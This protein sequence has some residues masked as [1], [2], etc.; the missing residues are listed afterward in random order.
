M[1][2][3]PKCI[4]AV[5]INKVCSPANTLFCSLVAIICICVDVT[6]KERIKLGGFKYNKQN[7]E[8]IVTI[9]NVKWTATIKESL[10]KSNLTIQMQ[11]EASH[12]QKLVALSQLANTLLGG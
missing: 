7:P 5:W 10:M 2:G 1:V 12:R 4:Q 9:S 8:E 6:G 3:I 11:W